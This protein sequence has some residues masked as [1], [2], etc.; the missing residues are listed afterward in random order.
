ML[1]ISL[2]RTETKTVKHYKITETKLRSLSKTSYET[3]EIS[4]ERPLFALPSS[5]MAVTDASL[6]TTSMGN[7]GVVSFLFFW[8]RLRQR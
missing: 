6:E 2:K 1:K 7:L 4:L 3:T 5:G 8:L